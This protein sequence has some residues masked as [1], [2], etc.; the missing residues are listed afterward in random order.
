M[1]AATPPIGC[2]ERYHTRA[3][4]QSDRAMEFL[5]KTL[6]PDEYGEGHA[7]LL[8]AVMRYLD[9]SKLS[10]EQIER[11]RVGDDPIAVLLG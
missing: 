11:L 7:A 1:P 4:Q 3:E 10:N 6:D 5:L 2:G 8:Q 9:M